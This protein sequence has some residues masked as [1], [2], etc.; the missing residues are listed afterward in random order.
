[1]F[2]IVAV[3][4]MLIHFMTCLCTG[5]CKCL[6]TGSELTVSKEVKNEAMLPGES[7]VVLIKHTI[8]DGTETACNSWC[9][10]KLLLT[11][12]CSCY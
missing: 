9:T 3:I 8:F 4:V 5:L 10:L 1:M 7:L 11:P 12:H 6:L 2:F